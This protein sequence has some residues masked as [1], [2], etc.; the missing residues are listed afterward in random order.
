MS[1][2][3]DWLDEEGYPTDA[4]LERI[5]AWEVTS[6]A[7]FDNLMDFIRD[8]WW[9]SQWGFIVGPD[10]RFY[11]LI[12]GGWSG[13]ESIIQAL[14]DNRMFTVFYWVLSE[15]GGKFVYAYEP[16]KLDIDTTIT[17]WE[18]TCEE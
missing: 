5:E 12:T 15:R 14:D 6:R 2:D 1:E 7:D 13:N 10:R 3:Y 8:L 17:S 9:M 4:A 18:E 11:T 16:Y